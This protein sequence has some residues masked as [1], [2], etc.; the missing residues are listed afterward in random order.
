MI[1][2]AIQ[3]RPAGIC[4]LT[5]SLNAPLPINLFPLNTRLAL[6]ERTLFTLMGVNWR[7]TGGSSPRDPTH[8]TGLS[9]PPNRKPPVFVCALRRF[10]KVRYKKTSFQY[11]WVHSVLKCSQ[12]LVR[13]RFVIQSTVERT[14]KASDTHACRLLL[15]VQSIWCLHRVH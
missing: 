8:N 5:L 6:H 7:N 12:A 15:S 9:K 2:T 3:V 14:R 1:V 13:D 4:V 11:H 10:G